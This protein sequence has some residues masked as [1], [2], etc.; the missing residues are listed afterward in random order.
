[1]YVAVVAVIAGQGLLFGNVAVLGY[2]ALVWLVF[3]LFVIA[4]EE[5]TLRAT[6]G[7]EYECF[8]KGVSRWKP[9][10]NPWREDRPCR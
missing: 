8:C 1:M 10:F 9:R 4:Y 7:E 5:P 2:G 6:F 3:H